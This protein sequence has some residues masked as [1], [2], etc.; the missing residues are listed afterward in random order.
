M[1]KTMRAPGEITDT[2]IREAIESSGYPLQMKVALVLAPVFDLIEEWSYVDRRTEEL[3]TLDLVASRTLLEAGQRRGSIGLRLLI[4]CKQSK[5]P[6]VFFRGVTEPFL[7]DFPAIHGIRERNVSLVQTATNTAASFPLPLVLGLPL[8]PFVAEGPP[9]C[10]TF[11]KVV[12]QGSSF[13]LSGEDPYKKVVLPLVSAYEHAFT[14]SRPENDL[15]LYPTLTLAVCVIAGPMVVHDAGTGA[16][17]SERWVRIVRHEAP[18]R[19]SAVARAG[20]TYV[21][22]IVHVDFLSTFISE[23]VK[24]FAE[25]FAERARENYDILRRGGSVDDLR[26]WRWNDIR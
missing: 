1:K 2:E 25:T 9:I 15:S 11:S 7:H 22:E 12:E 14:Q 26:T 4:E 24:P 18:E 8:E 3:R 16:I 21:F 13:G 19:T 17:A 23:K 10:A 6:Y 20:R 5:L